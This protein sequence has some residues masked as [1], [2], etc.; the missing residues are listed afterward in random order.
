MSTVH[1][2]E[3]VEKSPLKLLMGALG[4]KNGDAD[5]SVSSQP[6]TEMPPPSD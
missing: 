2:L 5:D 4:L 3:R 1:A 6:V